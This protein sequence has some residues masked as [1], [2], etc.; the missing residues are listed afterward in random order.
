MLF[1]LEQFPLLLYR[2]NTSPK[3][4]RKR[5]RRGYF[6]IYRTKTSAC[7]LEQSSCL[8]LGS[9]NA[10]GTSSSGCSILRLHCHKFTDAVIFYFNLYF[11][12][13]FQDTS[14][15]E[16]DWW[17]DSS[18]HPE[19]RCSAITTT[20]TTQQTH[21]PPSDTPSIFCNRGL[22]KWTSS[23]EAWRNSLF[24]TEDTATI[25]RAQPLKRR[26]REQVKEMLR[27][28]MGPHPLPQVVSLSEMIA[29]YNF[30]WNADDSDA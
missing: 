5:Q 11:V 30:I 7:A 8:S 21:L 16:E 14:F 6:Q 17:V 29:M 13:A 25:A 3:M 27:T 26:D 19:E 23:R 1:L 18:S 12:K 10:F 22:E 4:E 2:S 28:R 15:R 24:V 9:R 20:A